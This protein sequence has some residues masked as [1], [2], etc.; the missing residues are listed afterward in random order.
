LEGSLS[1]SRKVVALA[2]EAWKLKH[3]KWTQLDIA[4]KL[5]LTP[6]RVQHFHSSRWLEEKN[7]V[8]LADPKWNEAHIGDS[9][10]G[11]LTEG[12]IREILE[13]IRLCLDDPPQSAME[14]QEESSGFLLPL[15]GHDWALAP[16]RWVQLTTPDFEN[17]YAPPW[18]VEYPWG[19]DFHIWRHHKFFTIFFALLD[20]LK[21]MADALNEKMDDRAQILGALDPKFLIRWNYIRDQVDWTPE[22]TR[23][24]QYPEPDWATIHMP[25]EDADA[26]RI[27]RW[28]S[29]R[30]FRD[31][32]LQ[33]AAL[34]A[35]LIQINKELKKMLASAGQFA[36]GVPETE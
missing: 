10:E 25:Y 33:M 18:M 23:T 24:P 30:H 4:E 22:V 32:Y 5:G 16:H 35:K 31:I 2:T 8:H 26:A 11:E 34:D 14:A 9:T 29:Q 19:E 13:K 20:E 28:L 15:G 36:A 6:R 27:C 12:R 1:V 3:E 7:L 17:S 21:A